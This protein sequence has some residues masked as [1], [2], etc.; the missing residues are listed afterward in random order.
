MQWKLLI[1]R[2]IATAVAL[3]VKEN[4]TL[5]YEPV[6]LFDA[7][8]GR[9][10]PVPID[11]G[12]ATDQLFLILYGTGIRFR[13]TLSAVTATIG[14]EVSEVLYAGPAEGFV[15][16]DQC[17]LRIPRTLAGRGAVTVNLAVDGKTANSV[18]IQIK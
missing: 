3:R 7:A 1:K 15:G 13:S 4:G 9:F 18:T 12:P 6:A 14:G 10:V 2:T 5:S 17:N 11:L 16:L 8:Q